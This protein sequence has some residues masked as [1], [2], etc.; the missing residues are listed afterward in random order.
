MLAGLA[1][2]VTIVLDFALIPL[3]GVL[4]AALAS[5]VAYVVYGVASLV[6]VSR[7]SGVPVSELVIPTRADLALYPATV[8]SVLSRI[9]PSSQPPV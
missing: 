1:V 8:L 3:L 2:V 5:V 9:R 7:E 4:G 6:A